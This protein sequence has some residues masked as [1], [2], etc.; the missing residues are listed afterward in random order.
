MKRLV[1]IY[2][3]TNTRENAEKIAKALVE[4][5]LAACVQ[6]VGPVASVY[7]W[8]GQIE[9]TAEWLCIVKTRRSLYDTVGSAIRRNHTYEIPEIIAVPVVEGDEDYTSWLNSQLKK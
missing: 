7:W 2:T 5:R 9:E 8:R 6:I 1:Q 4:N 3:T